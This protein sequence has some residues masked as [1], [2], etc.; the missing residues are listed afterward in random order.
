VSM[1]GPSRERVRQVIGVIDITVG[2]VLTWIVAKARRMAVKA[3]GV[4]NATLDA[5]VD[6]VGEL[7]MGKLGSDSAIERLQVEAAE[8]GEISDLTRQRVGL[9]LQD[10]VNRDADFARHLAAA[11]AAAEQAAGSG[12]RAGSGGVA[13][14]GG[15][16]AKDGG[17]AF[18]VVTGGSVSVDRLDPHRPGRA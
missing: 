11:V 1:Y 3:D 5:A 17:V 7:V 4:V 9:A 15:V 12:A 16:H 10:A 2:L 18:G 6:R 8:P 14:A 13:I